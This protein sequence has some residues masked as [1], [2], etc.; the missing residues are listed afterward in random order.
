MNHGHNKVNTTYLLLYFFPFNFST[1]VVLTYIVI[2]VTPLFY[3]LFIFLISVSL[4]PLFYCSQ[5]KNL[6]FVSN[7]S[8]FRRYLLNYGYIFLGCYVY[9]F[10]YFFYS[11]LYWT[12]FYSTFFPLLYLLYFFYYFFSYYFLGYSAGAALNFGTYYFLC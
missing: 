1:K 8:K 4:F 12:F 10:Y 5:L 6:V 7:M 9:F 2:L 11:T 3:Y